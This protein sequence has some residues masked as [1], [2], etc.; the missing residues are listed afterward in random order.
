MCNDRGR[1]GNGFARLAPPFPKLRLFVLPRLGPSMNAHGARRRVDQNGRF[2]GMPIRYWVEIGR[3]QHR[4]G[5]V[6]CAPCDF[7]HEP[8]TRL[9]PYGHRE[10]HSPR[11][12]V[13]A[14]SN[15][16]MLGRRSHKRCPQLLVVFVAHEHGRRKRIEGRDRLDWLDVRVQINATILIQEFKTQNVSLLRHGFSCVK[17]VPVDHDECRDIGISPQPIVDSVGAT[18]ARPLIGP[19][20]LVRWHLVG[21]QPDLVE[22][23]RYLRHEDLFNCCFL[24]AY[25]NQSTHT[26]SSFATC[27]TTNPTRLMMKAM[28]LSNRVLPRST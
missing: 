8:G 26:D 20:P 5:R 16:W 1:L 22:I 9:E 15:D 2:D 27:R 11:N 7:R 24:C 21:T 13:Q 14:G 23:A 19:L 4:N 6:I 10:R 12:G 17:G 25:V 28:A 3:V 18:H